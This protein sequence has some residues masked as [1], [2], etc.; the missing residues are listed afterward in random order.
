MAQLD[1]F[2]NVEAPVSTTPSVE[3]VRA[4]VE[5]V[6]EALRTASV[7]PWSERETAR[8]KIVLPQMTDWL[9][10]EERDAARREFAGFIDRFE[11]PLAAQ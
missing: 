3:H 1:L 2:P 11:R 6:L 9:P 8:W 4:R 7:W 10:P 5:A